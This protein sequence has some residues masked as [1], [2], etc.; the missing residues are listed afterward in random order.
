MLDVDLRSRS[1]NEQ[2]AEGR[3]A[4]AGLIEGVVNELDTNNSYR[5]MKC[6]ILDLR[7]RKAMSP[8]LVL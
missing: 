2:P 5:K 6:L 3:K 4:K 8:V 7:R 1:L